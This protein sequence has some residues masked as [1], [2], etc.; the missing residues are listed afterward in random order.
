MTP[1][2]LDKLALQS[3]FILIHRSGPI[4][5]IFYFPLRP[6]Q[7][8]IDFPSRGQVHQTIDSNFLDFFP[9]PRAVLARV[10]LRGTFGYS[11]KNGGIGLAMS[12]VF[13]LKTLTTIYETFN[14]LGRQLQSKL[15]VRQ[16]FTIPGQ[17]YYWRVHVESVGTRIA[18]NDPL[19]Y[20]YEL[21]FLRLTD[22][23]SPTGGGIKDLVS[24]FVPTPVVSNFLSGLF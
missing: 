15:A 19:L 3:P 6:Q 17:G 16:E 23:L 1:T 18:N 20:Y 12:G 14:A 5:V 13:H 10:S 24:S 4:P 2:G 11:K 8:A 9:G 22:Y 7:V 21:S